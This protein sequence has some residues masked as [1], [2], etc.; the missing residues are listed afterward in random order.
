MILTIFSTFLYGCSSI[1]LKRQDKT[2]EE[3]HLE[4]KYG[5]DSAILDS[6]SIIDGFGLFGSGTT[7]VNIPI[8][9]TVALDK[10]SFMPLDSMDV[11][12]GIITTDWYDIANIEN[13]R[14]KF[15]VYILNDQINNDSLNIK[16]F[17]QKFNGSIWKST[18]VDNELIAKMKASILQEAKR[19]ATAASQ[20]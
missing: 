13:E 11:E 16:M 15:V 4:A 5:S 3:Q 8:L 19:M 14:V 9:Y 17:K 12:T 20:S 7:K 2:L 18:N 1:D 10:L 6:G